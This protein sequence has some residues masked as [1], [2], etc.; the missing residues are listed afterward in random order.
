MKCAPIVPRDLEESISKLAGQYPQKTHINVLSEVLQL[1]VHVFVNY[2]QIVC[3]EIFDYYYP[4]EQFE[5]TLQSMLRNRPW[6]INKTNL[7][8]EW[9]PRWGRL[10]KR[11]LAADPVSTATNTEMLH[12]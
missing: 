10:N 7:L 9:D 8:F 4:I 3:W 5:L 6:E 11:Q 2:R 12:S 1:R